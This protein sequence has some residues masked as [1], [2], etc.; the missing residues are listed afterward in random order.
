MEEWEEIEKITN[1]TLKMEKIEKAED[2]EFVKNLV[3]NVSENRQNIDRI[4]SS[5]LK[6]WDIQRLNVIERNILRI[7]VCE[8]LFGGD[9]PYKVAINEAVELAKIFGAENAASLI[10]GVLDKVA[11]KKG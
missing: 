4:I 1:K 3:K 9:V 10:N 11:H 6:D 2:K 8:L 5:Y 7:G